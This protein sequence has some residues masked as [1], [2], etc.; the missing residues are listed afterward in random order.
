MC[1][2]VWVCIGVYG[3]VGGWYVH[4]LVKQSNVGIGLE[5]I[6]GIWLLN[7]RQ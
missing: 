4:G 2:C 5:L 3:V 6:I 1:G 7:S